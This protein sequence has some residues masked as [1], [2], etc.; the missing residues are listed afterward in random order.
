MPGEPEDI[1]TPSRTEA[2]KPRAS[3]AAFPRG[4]Q[5]SPPWPRPSQQISP[6]PGSLKT[7]QTRGNGATTH[8]P[9]HSSLVPGLCPGPRCKRGEVHGARGTRERLPTTGVAGEA[10][11]VIQA[12]HCL[13]RLPCSVDAK[14]TLDAN[15]Y[16]RRGRRAVM[17]TKTVE[18]NG[19]AS[20]AQS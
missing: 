4:Q 19:H 8:P 16:G 15:A 1:S 3:G 2:P 13:A 9:P 20:D 12:P 5:K 10:I 18:L 6:Q 7:E 17:S 11:S 14:P